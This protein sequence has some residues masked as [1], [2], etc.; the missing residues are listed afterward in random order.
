MK[1][2]LLTAPS[3]KLLTFGGDYIPVEPV[4]GHAAIARRGLTHALGELVQGRD[5][6]VTPLATHRIREHRSGA[7]K[8]CQVQSWPGSRNAALHTENRLPAC[9]ECA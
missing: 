2:Y 3:N 4:I 7:R 1:K 9:G 5:E 6:P 8:R